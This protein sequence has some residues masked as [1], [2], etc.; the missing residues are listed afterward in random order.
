MGN[1]IEQTKLKQWCALC[2]QEARFT[3]CWNKFYCGVACQ[4]EHWT[5]HADD[6]EEHQR[7]N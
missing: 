2:K 6:C 3:F 7:S 5:Q 4:A 1:A